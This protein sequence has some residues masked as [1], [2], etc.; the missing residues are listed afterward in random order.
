MKDHKR[1]IVN[2]NAGLSGVPV[3]FYNWYLI[4]DVRDGRRVKMRKVMHK[5]TDTIAY[6][7]KHRANK[8]K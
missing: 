6:C 1:G 5:R 7:L 4:K 3:Y 8:Q 2:V